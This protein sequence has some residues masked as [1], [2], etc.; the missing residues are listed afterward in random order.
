MQIV[1]ITNISNG[2]LESDWIRDELTPELMA[3]AAWITTEYPA[4]TFDMAIELHEGPSHTYYFKRSPTELL[5]GRVTPRFSYEYAREKNLQSRWLRGLPA[6]AEW[7]SGVVMS[8]GR[9]LQEHA[10]AT[11][12]T[13]DTVL[14]HWAANLHPNQW[15]A[16]QPL[17]PAQEVPKDHPMSDK[18][19][20][21]CHQCSCRGR[22]PRLPHKVTKRRPAPD[23]RTIS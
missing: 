18:L 15:A 6:L 19:K 8:A 2:I 11:G 21:F 10:P 9:W 12:E 5:L 20:N 16:L 4:T 14:E 3:T 7:A 23:S 22:G 13:V 17:P 1:S